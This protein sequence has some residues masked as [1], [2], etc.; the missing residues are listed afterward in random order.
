MAIVQVPEFF[1]PDPIEWDSALAPSFTSVSIQTTARKVAF[2]MRVP[3]SGTL[4]RFEFRIGTVTQNP[5]NGLKVSFQ[6]VAAGFPDDNADQYYTIPTGSIVANSWTIPP[7]LTSDGTSGGTRRTVTQGDWLA[8]VIE[9]ASFA[10]GD[11]LV[12]EGVSRGAYN[13]KGSFLAANTSGTWA[14]HEDGGYPSMALVYEGDVY[15]PLVDAYPIESILT[16]PI[17][18]DE[19]VDEIGMAFTLT[20]PMRIGGAYVLVDPEEDFDVVLYDTEANQ[21]LERV[22]VAT[23]DYFPNLH[24]IDYVFVR[25]PRN[26]LLQANQIYVLSVAPKGTT[27]IVTVYDVQA[28]SAAQMAAMPC[29]A[30][31][32]YRD[33]VDAGDWRVVENRLPLFGLLVTGVDH[34]ISGGSGGGGWDGT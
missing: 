3:K 18:A 8:C 23:T 4:E 30:T 28:D 13:P 25:F 34:D 10:S 31:W 21:E 29:G 26:P 7:Y 27:G 24:H 20:A 22:T 9:F 1:L 2:I 14:Q 33:R 6:D 5:T 17:F 32:H 19:E 12:I 16:S 15:V 11:S